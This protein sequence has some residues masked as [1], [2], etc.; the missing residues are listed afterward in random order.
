MSRSTTAPTRST[1]ACVLGSMQTSTGNS[2]ALLKR[3]RPLSQRNGSLLTRPTRIIDVKSPRTPTGLKYTTSKT[4]TITRGAERR[5]TRR[6][7]RPFTPR[8][9]SPS[10]PASRWLLGRRRRGSRRMPCFCTAGWDLRRATRATQPGYSVRQK[11][12]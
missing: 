7:T 8:L 4:Q 11:T 1:I 6:C 2:G 5:A 10:N 3:L 9:P 12:R